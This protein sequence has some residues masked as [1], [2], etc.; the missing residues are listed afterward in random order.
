MNQNPITLYKPKPAKD[1]RQILDGKVKQLEETLL[2]G[3]EQ[4]ISVISFSMVAV[5]HDL[6]VREHINGQIM[7]KLAEF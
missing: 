3:T 6:Q 2:T 4:L 5:F 1:I 7:T